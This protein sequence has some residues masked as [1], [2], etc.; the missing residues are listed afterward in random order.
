M[1]SKK[2]D[3][4]DH[5]VQSAHFANGDLRHKER[6]RLAQAYTV[7]RRSEYKTRFELP[8]QSSLLQHSLHSDPSLGACFAERRGGDAVR[9]GRVE[10]KETARRRRVCVW[11]WGW[12]KEGERV[13]C[14]KQEKAQERWCW[15]QN[16][17]S[18]AD[19]RLPGLGPSLVFWNPCGLNQII[20]TPKC[21]N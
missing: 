15:D 2:F 6:K 17:I 12:E 19:Q 5:W 16:M 21:I 14:L 1:F 11:E 8:A 13:S 18:I 10:R 3:L 4:R 9:E 7:S 20:N